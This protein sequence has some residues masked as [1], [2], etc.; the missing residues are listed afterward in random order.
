MVA[1]INTQVPLSWEDQFVVMVM[2]TVIL[3]GLAA[4]CFGCAHGIIMDLCKTE[5]EIN[6]V[7]C[8]RRTCYMSDIRAFLD[9]IEWNQ[10]AIEIR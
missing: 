8:S 2:D 9:Q 7:F 6:P 5:W 4:F 10:P 3:L 1:D